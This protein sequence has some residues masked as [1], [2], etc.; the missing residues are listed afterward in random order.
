MTPDEIKTL[1][2]NKLTDAHIF[3]QEGHPH[4]RALIVGGRV[5]PNV[6]GRQEDDGT[7]HLVLDNRFG[8]TTTRAELQNWAWFL[9]NA[10]AV[11]AGFT[12]FGEPSHSLLR[13]PYGR[14]ASAVYDDRPFFSKDGD[15]P[16]PV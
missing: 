14:H 12:S 4:H 6:Q 5:V 2:F 10:M 3:E 11:A 15:D 16:P 7:V 1:P 8:I 9:A 13:N